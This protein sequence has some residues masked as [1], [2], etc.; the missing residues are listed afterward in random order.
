MVSASKREHK[1]DGFDSVALTYSIEIWF[2]N[3]LMCRTVGWGIARSRADASGYSDISLQPN[4]INNC[5]R[6]T[7]WI[8]FDRLELIHRAP[9]LT[10]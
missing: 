10:T 2:L 5:F 9:R 3:S 1:A 8:M 6:E 7:L 4:S